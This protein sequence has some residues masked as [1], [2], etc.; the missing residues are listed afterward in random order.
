M[1]KELKIAV[2]EYTTFD[3]AWEAA[4]ATREQFAMYQGMKQKIQY[5][6]DA[7]RWFVTPLR[8][9][10]Y[11]YMTEDGVR[12]IKK[13]DAISC[14]SSNPFEYVQIMVPMSGKG[15]LRFS[16]QYVERDTAIQ[17]SKTGQAMAFSKQ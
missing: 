6:R 14:L 17:Y 7:Q 10:Y 2:T 8:E 3:A 9:L 12:S 11:S 1:N 4:A 15:T 13:A 5:M 16:G